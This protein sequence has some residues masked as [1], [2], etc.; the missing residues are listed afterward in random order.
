MADHKILIADDDPMMTTMLSRAMTERGYAFVIAADAMQAVMFAMQK[1]PD[2]ILLDINMPAGTGHLALKRLKA[3]ARTSSIPVI[4]LS[5]SAEV[6]LP[7][8]VLARGAMAFFRKPIDLDA[9]FARLEELLSHPAVSGH[10]TPQA[11]G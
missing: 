2:A 10:A 1:Q 3:S 9:L 7:A 4:V 6:A 11:L 5:G 8:T